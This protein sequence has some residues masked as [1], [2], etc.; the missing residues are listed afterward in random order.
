MSFKNKFLDTVLY[1]KGV[2]YHSDSFQGEQLDVGFAHFTHD[3]SIRIDL[4]VHNSGES[5]N[6]ITVCIPGS[7]IDVQKEVIINA[8]KDYYDAKI[9]DLLQNHG[10]IS[11]PKRMMEKEGYTG[12]VCDLLKKPADLTESTQ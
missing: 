4:F 6:G 3:N 7:G 10:I 9:V 12:F 11:K 8:D 5:W 2:K 1:Y